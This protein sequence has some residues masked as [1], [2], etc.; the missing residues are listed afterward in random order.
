MSKATCRDAMDAANT[1]HRVYKQEVRASL[2]AAC[3]CAS[4]S[5]GTMMNQVITWFLLGASAV[6]RTRTPPHIKRVE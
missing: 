6:R 5:L 4:Y 1:P 3:N 2:I